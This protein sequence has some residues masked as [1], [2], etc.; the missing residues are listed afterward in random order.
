MYPVFPGQ[1]PD[2]R[3][4]HHWARDRGRADHR[5]ARAHHR[6]DRAQHPLA[7]VA[8]AAPPPPGPRGRPPPPGGP[9]RTGYYGPEHVARLKLIQELQATGYNLA[10]IKHLIGRSEGSA[11]EVRGFMR[12]LRAPFDGEPP[13][14]VDLAELTERFRGSGKTLGKAVA[15]GIL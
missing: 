5:R 14:V 7:P 1:R 4:R 9:P 13:E 8:R 3:V 6:D 10:A 11:E 15:L 2:S 12:P